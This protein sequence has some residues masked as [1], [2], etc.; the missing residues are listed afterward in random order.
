MAL[1]Y[2]VG[3]INILHGKVT[4]ALM[5]AIHDF[6]GKQSFVTH[7]SFADE[8]RRGAGITVVELKYNYK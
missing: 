3:F 7:F 2:N 1:L 8:D 5:E 6:L 4:G